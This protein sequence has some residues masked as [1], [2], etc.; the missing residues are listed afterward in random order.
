MSQNNDPGHPSRA[1]AECLVNQ[2][3]DGRYL[4]QTVRWLVV[5]RTEQRFDEGLKPALNAQLR[6]Y[7]DSYSIESERCFQH[8]AE[9]GPTDDSRPVASLLR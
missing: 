5:A 7:I 3:L 4:P 9:T 1:L 8:A 6:E 2:H